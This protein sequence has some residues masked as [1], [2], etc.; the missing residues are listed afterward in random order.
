MVAY[1][2][3]RQKKVAPTLGRE[4][5]S[6]QRHKYPENGVVLTKSTEQHCLRETVHVISQLGV[7]SCERDMWPASWSSFLSV[8]DFF[9]TES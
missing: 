5:E 2:G 1:L 3:R 8:W 9:L 7:I 6:I 4:Y